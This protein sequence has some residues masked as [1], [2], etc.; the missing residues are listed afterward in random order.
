MIYFQ[1]ASAGGLGKDFQAALSTAG[2]SINVGGR[3]Q[4]GQ[5]CWGDEVPATYA[6]AEQCCRWADN[7]FTAQQH[8]ASEEEVTVTIAGA[9]LTQH[10]PAH[11]NSPIYYSYMYAYLLFSSLVLPCCQHKMI[12][13]ITFCCSALKPLKPKQA[14]LLL[15]SHHRAM[16]H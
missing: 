8:S 4:R 9:L 15:L 12:S 14:L 11:Q 13:N 16:P 6:G 7:G 1:C 2:E 5:A 10:T 3:R